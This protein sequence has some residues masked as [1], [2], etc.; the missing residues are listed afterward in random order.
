MLSCNFKEVVTQKRILFYIRGTHHFHLVYNIA[1]ANP[2]YHFYFV[3]NFVKKEDFISS[4]LYELDNCFYVE[5]L[6]NLLCKLPMFGLYMTTDCQMTAAHRFSLNLARLFA[7]IGVKVVEL[8]H[9][10]FQLGLDYFDVPCKHNFYNDSLPTNIVADVFLSYAPEPEIKNAVAIGYPPYQNQNQ[11]YYTGNYTLVLSNLHWETYSQVEKYNFYQSVVNLAIDNPQQVFIW[12]RHHGEMVNGACVRM[13]KNIV[14]TL[15][16]QHQNLV[17]E[18]AMIDG[19]STEDL[20]A[21]AD[22]VISTPSTTLLDCEMAQKHTYVYACDTNQCLIDKMKIKTV[23]H[24]DRELKNIF[25]QKAQIQTGKLY[26]YNNKLFRDVVENNYR[27]PHPEK[28]T[29]LEDI[30]PYK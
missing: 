4:P 23:F 7:K 21:K 16:P 9:G 1:Q 24:K 30:V 11:N 10:L 5:D 6:S 8:E 14:N 13:L 22:N 17:L 20:I 29:Y 28:L 18:D 2:D 3:S 25:S 27:L 15:C 12:R 19:V 26:V